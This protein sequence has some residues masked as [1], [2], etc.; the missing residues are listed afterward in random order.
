MTAGPSTDERPGDALV[1][2]AD[3]D[4]PA[5]HVR[6]LR[7]MSE[8]SRE[9]WAHAFAARLDVPMSVLG[10]LFLLLVLAQTVATSPAVQRWLGVAGWALW[11]VFVAEYLLR[12][13]VAP[14]KGRFLRKT[15][16]QVVFLVVPFLRF[17][18]L[19]ALLRLARA[20]RVVS[21]AVRS[22]RSAGRLLSSRLGWLGALSAIV[23]LSASQL[24]YAFGGYDVYGDA[25]YDVALLTITGEPTGRDGAL[26][27]LLDVVL[28]LY[29]VG[30]FAVLAGSLGAFFLDDRRRSA[31]VPAADPQP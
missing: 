24:L 13:Y 7:A 30:V 23:V 8:D 18:R 20:G 14:S 3:D 29:S 28:A 10:V 19:V 2:S 4:R 15:W 26:A 22:S 1:A 9:R 31:D 16:W 21:S 11:A 5:T 25:L 12:L 27:R 6:R 17:L